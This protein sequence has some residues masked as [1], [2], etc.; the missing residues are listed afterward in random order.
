VIPNSKKLLPNYSITERYATYDIFRKRFRAR[1]L[2]TFGCSLVFS[3]YLVKKQ[4]WQPHFFTKYL[5]EFAAAQQ[6][7]I[8]KKH[9][10][11]V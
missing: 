3:G 11:P 5:E 2:A 9:C 6:K 10:P 7:S 1:L 4:G 8:F